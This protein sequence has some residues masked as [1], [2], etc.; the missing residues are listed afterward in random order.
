LA[1]KLD[2]FTADAALMES[3]FDITR[4]AAGLDARLAELVKIRVSQIN[5]CAHCLNLHTK[6]ARS[7][8]ESD[9]RLDVLA[10]WREAPCF[11]DRERAALGW[12]EA[13]TRMPHEDGIEAAFARVAG[14]FS[15]AELVRL[16]IVINVINGWNRIA[17]GFGVWR[18]R[19]LT[20]RAA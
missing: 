16:T 18:D 6:T 20:E 2:P 13:L 3:W 5:G 17:R 10:S 11:D 9:Q 12:A 7:L 14:E 19:P 4:A 15:D 8:G 1:Q